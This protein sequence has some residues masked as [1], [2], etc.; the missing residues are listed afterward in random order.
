MNMHHF[1]ID[2]DV[3]DNWGLEVKRKAL[4]QADD[5]GHMKRWMRQRDAQKRLKIEE[6]KKPIS[7]IFNDQWPNLTGEKNDC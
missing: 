1:Q 4:E 5:Y 3:K 6:N 7:S 2:E